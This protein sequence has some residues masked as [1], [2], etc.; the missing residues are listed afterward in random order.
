MQKQRGLHAA[1]EASVAVAGDAHAPILTNPTFISLSTSG[2]G[3][4]ENLRPRL[5][6]PAVLDFTGREEEIRLAEDLPSGTAILITGKPG[7][8]KTSLATHLAYGVRMSYADGELYADLRGHDDKPAPPEEVMGR[9]LQALGVPEQDI[10]SDPHSRL[11]IYRR[12]TADRPL[13]MI[14]DNAATEKQVRPLL[15]S[16]TAALVLVTSRSQLSGLE[17]V[18]R[19]DLDIFP[20][21]TSLD[22]LRRVTGED[23]TNSHPEATERVIS[24][25][26]HLPLALRIAA[27][28]LSTSRNMR[29][30]DLAAELSDQRDILEALEAGDLAIRAA[31]TLSYRKLG[32]GAKNAFKQLSHVAGKDFGSGICAALVG[33]DERQARK[34]LRKLRE[35]NLIEPSQNPGRYRFHD[36]LGMYS[37]EKS[38]GDPEEKSLSAIH[39]ML[40]WLANSATKVVLAASGRFGELEAMPPSARSADIDSVESAITW[41]RDELENASSAIS[42]AIQHKGPR[43][44]E[45]LAVSLSTVCE[46]TGDWQNWEE[47]IDGGLKASAMI[48]DSRDTLSLLTSQAN[49]ARYRREFR[50][51]LEIASQVYNR[52]TEAGDD[53]FIASGANL[54]GCLK[55][56]CG[57]FNEAIPFIEQSLKISRERGLRHQVGQALYNLGTIHRSSGNMKEA[58][59][60][61]DQD[62]KVCMDLGDELGTAETLNTLALTYS[63]SG[64]FKEAE[65]LHRQ[66]LD[67]F[68][69]IGNIH[70]V[71]MVTN[72]LGITLRRQGRNNEA[73]ALYLEDMELSRSVG[74]ASGEAL[75]QVNAAEVLHAMGKSKEAEERFAAA[76]C[77]FTDLG[78][79]ER[80]AR[81]LITQIPLLFSAGKFELAEEYGET[82]IAHLVRHQHVHEAAWAYHLLAQEY[83]KSG[84]YEKS[85]ASARSAIEM[86]GSFSAPYFQ[87]VSH[88]ICLKASLALGRKSESEETL[89]ALREIDVDA[90]L[91]DEVLGELEEEQPE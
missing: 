75:A 74:N 66:S 22:F 37:R 5:L 60:H 31:F 53:F 47:V 83:E 32:K 67:R 65:R 30:S 3:S 48:E 81:T 9:F 13:V 80:L 39:R 42:V 78:D 86:G 11:D 64:K 14:L 79:A 85:L 72:D 84:E 20:S 49:L 2:D 33:C 24:A 28:I 36:L 21:G 73:L 71:S 89:A 90:E 44:A 69:R 38:K 34:T 82:A 19:I 6:P 4:S 59:R 18:K 17:A 12:V 57:E 70:K 88:S 8:G 26:G 41:A 50:D 77:V 29:M 63:D 40:E 10:P 87:L 91:M 54:Y 27:N 25:C 68:K 76:V 52:A 7:V 62:L 51:G 56:D 55:M 61:F 23:I 58:I 46:F 15:P 16:G 1:G 45:N 43:D 35:A